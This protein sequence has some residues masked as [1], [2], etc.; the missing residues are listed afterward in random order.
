[1]PQLE[2]EGR[3]DQPPAQEIYG[4]ALAATTEGSAAVPTKEGT[5]RATRSAHE[6]HQGSQGS[7]RTHARSLFER[8]VSVGGECVGESDEVPVRF[9]CVP[10][11]WSEHF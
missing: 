1:M 11:G 5:P 10:S 4:P 2:A 6:N 9:G 3:R 8:Q 7:S